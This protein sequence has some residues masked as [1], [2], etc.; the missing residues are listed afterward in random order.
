MTSERKRLLAIGVLVLAVALV[1]GLFASFAGRADD[2]KTVCMQTPAAQSL[3][4]NAG[5]T[6]D[7]YCTCWANGLADEQ[8]FFD[9]VSGAPDPNAAARARAACGG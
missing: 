8:S 1:G 6:L 3:A 7:A 5:K 4:A 9:H 2:Y